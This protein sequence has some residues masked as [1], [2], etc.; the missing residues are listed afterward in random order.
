MKATLIVSYERDSVRKYGVLKSN[1]NI[2]WCK[3]LLDS[4]ELRKKE[5]EKVCIEPDN[6]RRKRGRKVGAPKNTVV[7]NT[8]PILKDIED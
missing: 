3:N 6:R 8:H 1:G 7:G 4:V 5:N 2:V